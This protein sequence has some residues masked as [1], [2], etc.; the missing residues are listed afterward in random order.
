MHSPVL[1]ADWATWLL[2]VVLVDLT[3]EIAEALCNIYPNVKEAE[4]E[5]IR[6]FAKDW[7]HSSRKSIQQRAKRILKIAGK[8]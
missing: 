5:A 2:Y 4:Q 6:L 7:K 8:N 3:D 1:L